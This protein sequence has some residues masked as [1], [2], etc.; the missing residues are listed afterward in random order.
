MA[1]QHKYIYKKLINGKWRYW[2]KDTKKDLNDRVK[3][4]KDKVS[5]FL[6]NLSS[7]W[8]KLTGQG[9]HEKYKVETQT[10]LNFW[11]DEK[12]TDNIHTNT[13]SFAVGTRGQ[14]VTSERKAIEYGNSSK[15]DLDKSNP[16]ASERVVKF[17]T[18]KGMP[19][20]PML[21]Y[22][23]TRADESHVDPK[24]KAVSM[25]SKFDKGVE[26]H[27]KKKLQKWYDDLLN[28]RPGKSGAKKIKK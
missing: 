16:Y 14:S 15:T 3:D 6:S 4:G 28:G 18:K 7:K 17:Y 8:D 19:A 20:G 1:K 12:L 2:Y 10:L 25:Q 27:K 21:R 22:Y 5:D 23:S 24:Y 13:K 26:Q 11:G 9:L